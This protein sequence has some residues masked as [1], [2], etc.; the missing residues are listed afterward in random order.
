[1]HRPN[2]FLA[3]PLLAAST[4]VCPRHR[5]GAS[6]VWSTAKACPERSEGMTVPPALGALAQDAPQAAGGEIKMTAKKYEFD[7]NIITVRKGEHVK[8][9]IT[10]LDHDHGFK[11]DAFKINERLKKG[12]P[13][14]VE[15]TADK[16]GTFPFQCSHFCGVGHGR[17]KGK[18]VV[19]E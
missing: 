4:M 7:P 14:T 16:A 17:M 6:P 3:V 10:A 12:A 8:L 15:F 1:M 2:S 18:I 5:T 9:V 11:L 13:V 19:A